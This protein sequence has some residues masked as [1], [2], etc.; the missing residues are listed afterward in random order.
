M[1]LRDEFPVL[2]RVAY[3]NAGTDGP[4]PRAASELARGELTAQTE[5]GRLWPHFERRQAL[6]ADLR[7]G[8]ASLL[9][10][11]VDD[12][13]VTTGTSYGLGC[14]LAGLDLGPGDEIVTSDNE[15]PGLL[16]PLIAARHRGATVRAV[17]FAELAERGRAR[18]RRSSPPRT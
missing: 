8:Y 4:V 5:E 10:C 1:A 6:T 3:L 7:A 11:D 18:R 9:G 12:V 17:P 15:H 16:G 2:E 13:A 14:V